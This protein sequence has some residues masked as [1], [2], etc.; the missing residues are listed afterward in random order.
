MIRHLARLLALS[1]AVTLVTVAV[2]MYVS[3]GAPL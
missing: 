1:T 3:A 2:G